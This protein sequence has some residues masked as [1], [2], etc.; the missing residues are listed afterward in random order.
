MIPP[1]FNLEHLTDLKHAAAEIL[2]Q[3]HLYE[4]SDYGDGLIVYQYHET[5]Q[6]FN[7]LCRELDFYPD[8]DWLAE[9]VLADRLIQHPEEIDALGLDNLRKVM[10]IHYKNEA[11]Y[12]GHLA[13]LIDEGHFQK[14]LNYLSGF[15]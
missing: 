8:F 6:Q 2:Q 10:C 9:T 1:T 5:I 14:L 4:A 3:E 13:Y 7:A 12:P 15:N 11:F